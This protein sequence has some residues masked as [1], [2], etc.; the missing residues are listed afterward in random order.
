MLGADYTSR[1]PP[2]DLKAAGI[3]VVSRYL[4]VPGYPKNLTLPEANELLDAGIAIVLNYETTATFMLEGFAGGVEAAK[5]ARAQ[6]R[7]LFAPATTRI[8]YSA[9]FD[10]TPEQVPTVLDFLSGAVSADGK[11][12]VGDYG[13]LRI[14]EAAGAAGYPEWQ[15]VA[16]SGGQWS[17]YAV[18]KQTGEQRTIG[19]V[20]VDINEIVDFNALGAWT[21]GTN[22][23][24]QIPASIG[25][26]WPDIASQ[27]TGTYDDSTAI[28]WADAG[29]RAAALYAQQARDAVNALSARMDP[30]AIAEAVVA[31]ITTGGSVD[32]PAIAAAV[33][34]L[35]G[36]KLSS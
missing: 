2:A 17:R 24:G 35:F 3:S 9:D 1:I 34:K 23:S 30:N 31:H 28:I 25:Q 22:V 8:F 4:S 19:G 16:W 12:E 36:S 6:A 18:M 20:D 33:A 10:V 27:F 14:V 5:S 7:A 15:T 13:G 11:G 29:A 26:K 32:I 21:R